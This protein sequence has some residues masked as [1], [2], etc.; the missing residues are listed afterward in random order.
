MK[1]AKLV[2]LAL[3][4]ATLLT[5]HSSFAADI[6]AGVVKRIPADE[7]QPLMAGSVPLDLTKL[8]SV[9]A[10]STAEG[11]MG[12]QG[13][14]S[15]ISVFRIYAVQSPL[16]GT[17]FPNQY[18]GSTQYDH[19][20]NPIQVFVLQYGYGNPTTATLNGAST[21]GTSRPLCGSLTFLHYCN[22]G[23]T[24]TGWLYQ[25]NF[26]NQ[27]NGIFKVGSNSVAYPF[28]YWSTSIYVR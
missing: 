28:G 18:A 13:P 23:E 11:Q 5:C 10:T 21:S 22:V 20:G 3:T 16:G 14:A 2:K 17:E 6:E 4:A 9:P 1:N 12:I 26:Y 7:R 27:S 25:Y 15:G 24:V 8:A 19:G